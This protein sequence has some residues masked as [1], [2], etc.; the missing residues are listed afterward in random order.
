MTPRRAA[1]W[2]AMRLA[3]GAGC[4]SVWGF[5]L[6]GADRALTGIGA[7]LVMTF[8]AHSQ[9]Q[10]IRSS[11]STFCFTRREALLSMPALLKLREGLMLFTPCEQKILTLVPAR[12]GDLL[13]VSAMTLSM[14]GLLAAPSLT[15][16]G[17]LGPTAAGRLATPASDPTAV[18]A[19]DN[20]C[21]TTAGAGGAAVARGELGSWV[22]RLAGEVTA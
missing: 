10:I 5:A 7:P 16:G 12:C 3:A 19:A 2:F 21:C 1:T 14:C 17:T 4:G 18:V 6:S 15:G 8:L 9:R 11:A 20:G 22:S 13:A